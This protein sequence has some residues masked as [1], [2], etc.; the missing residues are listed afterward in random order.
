MVDVAFIQNVLE[1]TIKERYPQID[2][3]QVSKADRDPNWHFNWYS[4]YL[5]IKY[6]NLLKMDDAEQD[7]LK[8][9]V[10]RFFHFIIPDTSQNNVQVIFYDPND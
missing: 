9:D 8:K 7:K 6:D 2:T 4:I 10:K 1:K 3:I 5:G